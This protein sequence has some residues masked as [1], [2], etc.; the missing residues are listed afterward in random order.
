MSI[1]IKPLAAAVAV[2]LFGILGG[3][4]IGQ[5]ATA[6]SSKQPTASA[7]S[8]RIQSAM[9]RELRMQTRYQKQAIGQLRGFEQTVDT[10]ASGIGTSET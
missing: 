3:L 1:T 8:V 5:I 6:D 9:L 4:A 10:I 7:S 2:A